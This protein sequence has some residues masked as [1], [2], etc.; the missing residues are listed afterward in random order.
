MNEDV[1][2][3]GLWPL[4]VINALIFIIFAFS[5]FKPHTRRD[6]RTFGT[7][8]AF[9]VA[10]FTEMYGFPLT[11]YVLAGW[12]G[13]RFP[14]LE[15]LTHNS[16][17]LWQALL[18]WE[19]DPHLSPI[20]LLSDGFIFAGFMLLAAAWKVLYAAQRTGTVAVSG[21]YGYMRHPQYVAFIAIMVGFLIQWPTLITLAMFPVLVTM[22]VRLARREERESLAAF[23]EEYARYAA[24]TPAFIPRRPPLTP[25]PQH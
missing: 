7:F 9:L 19:G 12:L 5:F 6:W 20:H 13:G 11:I 24:A 2:A 14:G 15:R 10:L 22:Y 18:G 1:P 23:A 25:A 8:S 3:Y 16:G 4:V 21:P 17:H